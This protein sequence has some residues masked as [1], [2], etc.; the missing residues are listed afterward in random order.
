[1]NIEF[2]V[3]ESIGWLVTNKSEANRV[4]VDLK[5][6]SQKSKIASKHENTSSSWRFL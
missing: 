4:V 5:S 2:G 3:I 1:M 6:L